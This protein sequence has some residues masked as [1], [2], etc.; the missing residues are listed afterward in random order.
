MTPSL[1]DVICRFVMT[2]QDSAA[3]V[4]CTV[5]VDKVAEVISFGGIRRRMIASGSTIVMLAWS[6][7]M[8]RPSIDCVEDGWVNLIGTVLL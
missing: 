2:C 6:S 3:E 4:P 7:R 5:V 1:R 8:A